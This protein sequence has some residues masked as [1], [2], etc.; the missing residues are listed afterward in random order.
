MD[1]KI[2]KFTFS[3]DRLAA[4]AFTVIAEANSLMLEE[5]DI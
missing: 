5:S 1:A 4:L 2:E 3:N